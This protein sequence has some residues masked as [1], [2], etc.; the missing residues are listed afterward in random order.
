MHKEVLKGTIGLAGAC[1][2]GPVR[3]VGLRHVLR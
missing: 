1:F 2:I 3:I